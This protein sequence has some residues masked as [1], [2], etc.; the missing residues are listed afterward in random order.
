VPLFDKIISN[1][2]EIWGGGG[3]TREIWAAGGGTVCNLT[4][5]R[6]PPLFEVRWSGRGWPIYR[7]T[8]L[9]LAVLT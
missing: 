7:A 2:R 6:A 1:R 5:T 4:R 9:V 8:L 3:G